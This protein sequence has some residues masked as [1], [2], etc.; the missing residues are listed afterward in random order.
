[1]ILL[2]SLRIK[3]GEKK[4]KKKENKALETHGTITQRTYLK[5]TPMYFKLIEI[6][7]IETEPVPSRQSFKNIQTN[8]QTIMSRLTAF[9][10]SLSC[11]CAGV[12]LPAP[13]ISSTV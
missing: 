6:E 11:S 12:D 10:S 2:I 5:F 3:K 13:N 1:M 8:K 4:T 9:L 7:G